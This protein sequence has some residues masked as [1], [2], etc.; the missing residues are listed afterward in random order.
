M[1]FDVRW[2]PFELAPDLPKGRG[3]DK[4]K[5]Y[6]SKFGAAKVRGMIPRMKAVAQEHGI[7]MEYGGYVG[8]TLDSHRLIWKA[9]EMGGSEL[10]DKVVERLFKAYFEENK[11][12]GEQSVLEEC[13][14]RAGCDTTHDTSTISNFLSDSTLGTGEVRQEMQEYG[15]TFQCRG[16]PMFI[17]DENAVL[18]GA[19]ESD[20]F[21]RVFGRL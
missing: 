6:E 16:V 4:M 13:A 2:R 8:N 14:S 10:Q 11:S 5:H 3:Y 15:R 12:L 18:S 7:Q 19:Q 21:L 17:V 20:A 9:R 1:T